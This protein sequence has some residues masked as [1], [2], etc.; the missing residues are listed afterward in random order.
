MMRGGAGLGLIVLM[1]AMPA[2]AGAVNPEQAV[3]GAGSK[4]TSGDLLSQTGE[5]CSVLGSPYTETMVSGIASYGG[6]TGVPVVNQRYYT[7]FLVSV[8]GDPCGPGSS[9]I[10]TDVVL[11]PNTAIDPTAPIRCFGEPR[12]ASTFVELT[13]GSWSFDGYS[14]PYCPI[15]ATPSA[16]HTGAWSLGF[17]P[18]ASGQL[19]QIFVPVISTHP[20][21]G[22]GTSPPDGFRWLTDATGVYAN[23]GLSTVWANVFAAASGLTPFVYFAHE[24]AIPFWNTSGSKGPPDERNRLELF[25]NL[26]SGGKT[27]TL[28]F[29]IIRLLD[30]TVRA[31]C[32]TGGGW[33]G[34]VPGGEPD[35]FQVVP[36]GAASTGPN[37]GYVPP[38]YFNG[39]ELSEPEWGQDM[40]IVWTFTYSGGSATAEAPF[41]TLP[42]PDS[43]G[44]GIPDISDACPSIKGTLPNGCQPAVQTDAD[45][46]GVFGS[47]DL[48]P[49]INGQGALN[50][51]PGGVVP[52]PPVATLAQTPL[53]APLTPAVIS[54]PTLT[55]H[56][57]SAANIRGH[58]VVNTGLSVTC[59]AGGAACPVALS[60]TVSGPQ[61]TGASVSR[62]K[63]VVV[64]T[65]HTSVPAGRTL[66]LALRLSS[67]GAALLKKHHKLKIVLAGTARTGDGPTTRLSGTITIA[68]PP[69]KHKRRRA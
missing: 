69:T 1:L 40:K 25:A 51:C 12:G 39:P 55:H 37:G 47:A 28:C 57:V 45:G 15:T 49:T 32:N 35:L 19:F 27:G 6:T 68:N 60:G 17:R 41:H 63:S 52:R 36:L 53:T 14:G 7:A 13:G 61:A 43:D 48:C 11:P 3:G 44:D 58:V 23:P 2:S 5:N 18:L 54:A 29:H 59:P 16:L 38:F 50:G 30:S 46:D 65:L 34:T 10:E 22:I 56:R 42:G 20:L 62:T 4:W 21:V 26:Y 9:S 24:P 8:P 31:D 66:V 33:N 64:G 67:K